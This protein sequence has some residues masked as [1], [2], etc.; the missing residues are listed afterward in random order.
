VGA[1]D[2][3]LTPQPAASTPQL[4]QSALPTVSLLPDGLSAL[5]DFPIRVDRHVS[6]RLSLSGDCFA[7]GAAREYTGH[8]G[9]VGAIQTARQTATGLCP[10]TVYT[11]TIALTDDQGHF[12]TYSAAA[13][14]D[15]AHQWPGGYLHTPFENI[16]VDATITLTSRASFY[17]AWGSFGVDLSVNSVA[18]NYVTPFSSAC[19]PASTAVEG[20][21]G[22]TK[23]VTIP[24]ASTIHINALSTAITEGL[25]HGVNHDANCSW[26]DQHWYE[27]TIVTD[28]SYTDL[29]RGVTLSSVPTTAQPFT[30]TMHLRATDLGLAH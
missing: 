11:A 26:T 20:I 13:P 10:N 15:A 7:P 14:T 28:L 6:Y 30:L 2:P 24:L 21:S 27:P 12:A 16:R 8:T 4:D 23:T 29:E 17:Y 19:F 9:L 5:A 3:T 1:V 25:Y 22:M 18:S